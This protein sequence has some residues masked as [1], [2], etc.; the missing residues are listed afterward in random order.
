MEYKIIVDSREQK[1]L[2]TKDVI[3]KKLDTGDYSMIVSGVDYKDEFAIEYKTPVDIIGTLF[4]G[5]DRFKREL[6]RSKSLKFFC[7]LIS[8]SY[9]DLKNKQFKGNEFVKGN[10][11]TIIKILETLIVKYGIKIIFCE[12]RVQSKIRIKGLIEAYLRTYG[13]K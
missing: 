10:T 12:N 5:H 7:I 4:R 8:C 2:F 1:P 11:N 6:K 13:E 9:P 3:V